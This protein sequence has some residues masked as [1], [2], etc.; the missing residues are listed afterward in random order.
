MNEN[1]L[2]STE[3]I[4][5]KMTELTME[6]R[7]LIEEKRSSIY[8]STGVLKPRYELVSEAVI[9]QYGKPEQAGEEA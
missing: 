1:M 7:A 4:C 3:Q 6:A 2:S 9:N 8:R 5:R